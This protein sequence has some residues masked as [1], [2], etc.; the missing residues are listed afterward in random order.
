MAVSYQGSAATFRIVGSAATPHTLFTIENTAG[1]AVVVRIR[2]LVVQLD[3]TVA[4]T[5]VMPLVKTSRA[6]AIP[7]GG[8]VLAKGKFDTAQT[9]AAN[10]ILRSATAS[11]GGVA[12]AITATP[13][14]IMWQQYCMRLHTAVGQ[15]LSSDN[16]LLP[17]LIET[18]P[19]LL[20]ANQAIMCQV[21]AAAGTSNPATNHWYVQ[22]MWEEFA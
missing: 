22:C 4:L 5:A 17:T 21:V 11:D 7:T 3:A 14:D 8:T 1:S 9:S 13:G 12:T 20:A 15:V 6:A 10:V 2:R 16:P 18:Y 19:V